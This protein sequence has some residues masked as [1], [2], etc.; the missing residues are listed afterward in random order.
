MPKSCASALC[1]HGDS[2]VVDDGVLKRSTCEA[3]PEYPESGQCSGGETS[4]CSGIEKKN[5]GPHVNTKNL[6]P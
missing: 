6:T 4:A 3:D 5:W 2:R 1:A